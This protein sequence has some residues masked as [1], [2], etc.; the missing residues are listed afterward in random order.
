TDL[1]AEQDAD[2]RAARPVVRVPGR[3][4]DADPAPGLSAAQSRRQE[5][6]LA[7]HQERDGS[8][9]AAILK[10]HARRYPLHAIGC[11]VA[12]SALLVLGAQRVAADPTPAVDARAHVNLLRV[13]GSINPAI[14]DY[15]R[16]GIERSQ[17]DGAAA[18]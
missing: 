9:G 2:H 3:A 14:A 10:R 5:A 13:D 8:S 11:G 6:R 4:A 7:G 16:H 15:I 1:A 17:E 18:L 12:L